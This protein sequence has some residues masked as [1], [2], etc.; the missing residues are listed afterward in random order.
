MFNDHANRLLP[1]PIKIS[2]KE[3]ENLFYRSLDDQYDDIALQVINTDV[4]NM[5]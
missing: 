4:N 3:S 1:I 5:S 2:K